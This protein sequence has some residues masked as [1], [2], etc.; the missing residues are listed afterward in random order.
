[1]TL[2]WDMLWGA[3]FTKVVV[4]LVVAAV[5]HRLSGR[6]I[7]RMVDRFLLVNSHETKA[8]RRKRVDTVK[9]IFSTTIAWMIW[10]VAIISILA[11]F[12]VNFASIATGAG[13]VSVII[14]LGAQNTIR[15]YLA[16]MFIL[17]ENQYRVGDV[18]TLSGGSTGQAVSGVVEEITLRIT[19]LRDLDGTLNVVRNGEASVVTNRT[20]RYSSMV[21]DITVEYD[22]DMDKVER[23]M[24]EVGRSMLD[25]PS[26]GA[27]IEEP[28]QFLR[29]EA[30]GD[31]GVVVRAT[32][33]VKPAKQW[34]V[35]G[36]YRR[37]LLAAFRKAGIRI[38][39][40]QLV[41]HQ[42]DKKRET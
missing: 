13:L 3:T 6:L 14:G 30:L 5:L 32:G 36:E 23:T 15:D 34:E 24:N 38:A 26:I 11:I 4:V 2:D 31:Q 1:M 41:V 42:A 18:V 29:V 17:I 25:D 22:S 39:Y 37:R 27:E 9:T 20:F 33:K 40:P 19:K 7:G 28:V 10:I 12:N 16:G 35:A 8:E 21:I